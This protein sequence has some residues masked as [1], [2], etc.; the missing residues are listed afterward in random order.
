M[1][2]VW[3]HIVPEILTR[4]RYE[5]ILITRSIALVLNLSSAV[6]WQNT[7]YRI[8]CPLANAENQTEQINPECLDL[9][10]P[11]FF[12][13]FVAPEAKLS[14]ISKC[15][16]HFIRPSV[17]P[18]VCLAVCHNF[19]LLNTKFNMRTKSYSLT[20]VFG[21]TPFAISRVYSLWQ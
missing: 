17:Y 19:V 14:A 13:N 11:L 4:R 8:S 16:D 21:L 20:K 2:P 12:S 3:L 1:I 9:V 10:Y 15:R 6:R 18:P 7:R 5:I